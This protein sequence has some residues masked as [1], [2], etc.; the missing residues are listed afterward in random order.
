MWHIGNRNWLRTFG[1]LCMLCAMVVGYGVNL[2]QHGGQKMKLITKTLMTTAAIIAFMS[3]AYAEE[4]LVT[5]GEA[6]YATCSD[7]IPGP[8][9]PKGDT[10]EQ[11]DKGDKGDTGE[12]GPKGDKGDVGATGPQGP[13]GDKGDPGKDYDPQDLTEIREGMAAIAA[14]NVPHV[15]QNKRFSVSGSASTYDSEIGFGVGAAVRFNEAWQF[16][17]TVSTDSNGSAFAAKGVITGEW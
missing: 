9:G 7:P 16:G 17:G 3:S 2:K 8:Q 10:G 15:S 4:C 6:L 12:Q 11:G 13:K 14:L 1:A 5:M